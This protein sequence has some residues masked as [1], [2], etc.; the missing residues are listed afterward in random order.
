[1]NSETKLQLRNQIQN[2][3]F[4]L[5]YKNLEYSELNSA[6]AK[7]RDED[8]ESYR[9]IIN[10]LKEENKKLMIKNCQ[11]LNENTHASSSVSMIKTD[12]ELRYKNKIKNL[13]RD[14]EYM[15]NHCSAHL[16]LK[17]KRLLED[18]DIDYDID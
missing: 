10:E 4:E 13:E 2:L 6:W 14:I 5:A 7:K 15:T 9:E 11:L 1:M 16:I 18:N 12:F 8:G 17:Y 3:Q